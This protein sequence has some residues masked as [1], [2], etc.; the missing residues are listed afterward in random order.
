MISDTDPAENELL[1]EA[2]LTDAIRA[3]EHQSFPLAPENVLVAT[4][5]RRDGLAEFI[6]ERAAIDELRP[7]AGTD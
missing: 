6:E 5:E 1:G 7:L 4:P 2:R 3:D